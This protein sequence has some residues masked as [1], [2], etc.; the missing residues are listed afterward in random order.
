[1]LPTSEREKRGEG[2]KGNCIEIDK[3]LLESLYRGR[4]QKNSW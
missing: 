4:N 2:E 1:M 3:Q